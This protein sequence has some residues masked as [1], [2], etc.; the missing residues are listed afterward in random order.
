ML[1][2]LLPFSLLLLTAVG[3]AQFSAQG[4]IH[5]DVVSIKENRSGVEPG[6]LSIPPGGN[7]IV[8]TN[9][10]MFRVIGFAFNRQRN[11]LI[12]GLPGW[13]RDLRWDIEV[14]IAEESVAAFRQM[15]FEQQKEVLQQVLKERCELIAHTGKKEVP[16][17]AL[18]V[19]KS[20][21][22]IKEVS[23]TRT[24]ATQRGWDMTQSAGRVDGR[25]VP[26]E[27]L[28]YAL[29]K[30]GLERQIIDRTGLAG[31]YDIS[32]V[33]TPDDK[34]LSTPD[35]G[36]NALSSRTSIFTAL[37]DEL[38]LKMEATKADVDAVIV[39]RINKP[40]AN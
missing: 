35:A 3:W 8:A 21:T 33:W 39:T 4:A 12:E 29:S 1:K 6:Y 28:I 37:Q 27:A 10:P 2:R 23:P 17:Y 18:V 38:G 22:K 40:S 14:T 19:S 7:K 13:A 30:V 15:S 32:L 5:L 34:V 36:E 9:S 31:R 26:M 11:D 24:D 25:A 20:G 16:V